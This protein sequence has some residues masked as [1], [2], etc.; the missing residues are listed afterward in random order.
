MVAPIE[1]LV[2]QDPR[3]EIY[4]LIIYLSHLNTSYS[5]CGVVLSHY[6]HHYVAVTMLVSEQRCRIFAF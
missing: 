2:G 6:Y 4:I 5:S 3:P 1:N